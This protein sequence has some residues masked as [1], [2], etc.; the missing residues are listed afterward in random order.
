[1]KALSWFL[2]GL[3]MI[4]M[5]SRVRTARGNLS[6][7][8][9]LPVTDPGIRKLSR[10]SFQHFARCTLEIVGSFFWPMGRADSLME[11][12]EQD[13]LAL[14]AAAASGKG[15][16]LLTGHLGNW[17]VGG[18]YFGERYPGKFAVVAKRLR[19]AWLDSLAW[20]LR[21]R[22]GTEV[23]PKDQAARGVLRALK[24][25]K[26]VAVLMD[27]NRPDGVFA[28]FFGRLAAT[29]PLVP[30]LAARTGASV[31]PTSVTRREDG[32]FELSVLPPLVFQGEFREPGSLEEA[33]ATC[34]RAL[35][36]M[37]LLHPGQWL[38]SH[39]R[40]KTRPPGE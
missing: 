21:S 18:H 25:G 12:P 6:Q 3:L 5:P 9:G 27:Q 35:E 22:S 40:F 28:P 24:E 29:T 33:V 37:I 17:E 15:A 2:G 14:D 8:L 26:L 16:L 30:M 11:A 20:G 1:M 32:R 36:T 31:L 39:R 34:N 4:I 7:A 38:W 19:P 13:L 23:I 10:A